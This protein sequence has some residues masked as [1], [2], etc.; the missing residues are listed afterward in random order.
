MC[1][2]VC[3]PA[4]VCACVRV[5]VRSWSPPPRFVNSNDETSSIL[6]HRR[7][8]YNCVFPLFFYCSLSEFFVL[9]R[10]LHLT[11]AFCLPFACISLKR[12]H[13]K[14]GKRSV[15]G[16]K[17]RPFS[18]QKKKRRG[19]P[20]RIRVEPSDNEADSYPPSEK[21]DS[22][23]GVSKLLGDAIQDF[24]SVCFTFAWC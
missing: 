22:S 17:L 10:A 7:S 5:C 15:R 11:F 6:F 14:S 12:L 19:R 1:M 13:I 9:A 8:N 16:S 18:S 21:G 3:S 24:V 23:D 4:F 2:H 20:P